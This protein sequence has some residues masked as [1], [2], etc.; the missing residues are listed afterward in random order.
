MG[1]TC[2]PDRFLL[3][4]NND[5]QPWLRCHDKVFSSCDASDPKWLRAN[6]KHLHLLNWLR[7]E[8]LRLHTLWHQTQV[9]GPLW[10]CKGQRP[11][12]AQCAKHPCDRGHHVA[13]IINNLM[14]KLRSLMLASNLKDKP[15]TYV[16]LTSV[17]VQHCG[18]TLHGRRSNLECNECTRNN[19][20]MHGVGFPWSKHPINDKRTRNEPQQQPAP[21]YTTSSTKEGSCHLTPTAQS[22]SSASPTAH[23]Q[24]NPHSASNTSSITT[25]GCPRRRRD[26]KKHGGGK[27]CVG[28]L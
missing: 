4:V 3:V 25:Q 2:G 8:Y 15:R 16:A 7:D 20:C 5:G 17:N 11:Y 22:R 14:R 10:G 13:D 12:V 26:V 9:W 18:L 27:R 23:F 6:P 24:P 21:C 19:R 28:D 1:C